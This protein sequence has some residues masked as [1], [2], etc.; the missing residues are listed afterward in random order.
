MR[1][2]GIAHRVGHLIDFQVSLADQLL[3]GL[4][5]EIP[6]VLAEGDSCLAF[7][8]RAEIVRV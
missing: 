7:E 4:D 6:Q 3:G 5:A 8:Q 2:F 1:R